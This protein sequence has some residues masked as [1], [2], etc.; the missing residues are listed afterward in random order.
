MQFPTSK[1]KKIFLIYE[2]HLT[3]CNI[4]IDEAS[5]IIFIGIYLV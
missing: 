1:D 5:S 3:I 2:K 4:L